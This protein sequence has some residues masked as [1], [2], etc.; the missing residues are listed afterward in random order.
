MAWVTYPQGRVPPE[1]RPPLVPE[2][3]TLYYGS[4]GT[5]WRS[6]PTTVGQ[7][8]REVMSL[9]QDSQWE[10]AGREPWLPD[11]WSIHC[12]LYPITLPLA[13][14]AAPFAKSW[15][16]ANAQGTEASLWP[17]IRKVLWDPP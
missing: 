12:V 2:L 6:S 10:E 16:S 11:S 14:S 3:H 1:S 8:S 17:I 7:A 9:S 5:S 13:P 4:L 15:L